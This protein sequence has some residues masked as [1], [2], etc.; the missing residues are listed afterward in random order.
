MNSFFSRNAFQIAI[1]VLM[2]ISF[3][4][5]QPDTE[6]DSDPTPTP[7]PAPT[8]TPT[9]TPAPA[10]SIVGE[11]FDDAST[12]DYKFMA[13]L[14]YK[15]NGT[16]T[17]WTGLAMQ[18][19]NLYYNEEG[20]YTFSGNTLTQK[21]IDG[22]LGENTV[23][24]CD[25]RTLDKY[26]LFLYYSQQS[27]TSELH[28]I[29]DTYNLTVGESKNIAID[30]NEFVPVA[31]SSTDLRVAT[32]QNGSIRAVKRGTAYVSVKSSIGTAVIRVVVTDPNNVIDD[33]LEYLGESIDDVT[34]EFGDYCFQGETIESGVPSK[35]YELLDEYVEEVAFYYNSEGT[36]TR[37]IA[38]IRLGTSVDYIAKALERKH[39]YKYELEG[40]Y[41]YSTIKDGKEVVVIWGAVDYTIS[42]DFKYDNTKQG[43]YEDYDNLILLTAEQAAKQLGCEITNVDLAQGYFVARVNNNLFYSVVVKFDEKSHEVT[44]VQLR[45]PSDLTRSDIEGWYK[46]HYF[47]TSYSYYSYANYN[48]KGKDKDGNSVKEGNSYGIRFGIDSSSGVTYVCYEKIPLQVESESSASSRESILESFDKLIDMSNSGIKKFFRESGLSLLITPTKNS[49]WTFRIKNNELFS[50]VTYYQDN[51]LK[52]IHVSGN[53]GKFVSI[54][55]TTIRITC[56]K[57]ITRNDI[58]WWY[59]E[60]YYKSKDG[61]LY[62]REDPSSSSLFRLY[63]TYIDIEVDSD[64][65]TTIIYTREQD[66]EARQL[67]SD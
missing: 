43:A 25:V 59:K 50:D 45:C 5:C 26:N 56:C 35:K 21:Y 46:E 61:H 30:D 13:T 3:D 36:V 4:S 60:H 31:Y 53:F 52:T 39:E 54:S 14:N 28:R 65:L 38:S 58:E 32:V 17:S 29:I 44:G 42:Y 49:P 48:N 24:V 11:W 62:Q 41:Y 57:G 67:L 2:V 40:D 27:S 10:Y 22:I 23:D 66:A 34:K 16:F 47:E 51:Y 33:Y 19:R 15:E 55:Y 20:T 1:A 7:A 64:G 37:I 9:P 18:Q 6:L 8:P 12:E 63:T